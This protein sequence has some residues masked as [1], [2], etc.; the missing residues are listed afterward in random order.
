MT[1]ALDGT[2]DVP[3]VGKQSKKL[4]I[5]GGAVVGMLVVVYYVRKKNGA[6]ATAPA[7]SVTDQYPPDGTTGNSSDLYSTDPATGQTYGDEAAGSGGTLGAFGSGAASG[8]Y[9]DP[10][11]G[12]YDLSSPYGTGGT[13]VNSGNPATPGG[14]PFANN[15]AWTDWAIQELQAQNVNLDVGALTDALGVYLQGLVPTPAQK[16]LIFDATAIAG[17]PPV[18]GVDGYP[19]K[20][21]APAQPGHEATVQVP[22]V[23]GLTA[24]EAKAKLESLG[25]VAGSEGKN[26]GTGIVNSQTPGAGKVVPS[27][28]VVNLGL[29]KTAVVPNVV[30]LGYGEAFNHLELAGFKTFPEHVN[31]AWRVTK[32]SP[33]SGSNAAKGSTVTLTTVAQKPVRK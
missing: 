14:P 22:K 32:Q 31:S 7:G 6:P 13:G 23:T 17:N 20:V 30:G 24:T 26:G 27:G 1:S 16:T 11:T 18:P 9:Y 33:A 3:V 28:S 25:L 15:A 8:Q 4:V 19:P 29:A 10:S 2:V 12:A 5:G 21:K